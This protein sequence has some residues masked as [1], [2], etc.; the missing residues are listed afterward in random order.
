M[1]AL[2]DAIITYAILHKFTTPI[3]QSVAYKRG[4]VDEQGRPTEKAKHL[5]S[6]SDR[7]A[8]TLLDRL[9]F[10]LKRMFT[11]M[12]AFAKL[13]GGYAAALSFI[14]ESADHLDESASEEFAVFESLDNTSADYWG[15]VMLGEAI[16]PVELHHIVKIAENPSAL[17]QLVEAYQSGTQDIIYE[18]G[19]VAAAGM[20]SA[21]IGNGVSTGQVQGLATEPVIRPETQ[22]RWKDKNKGRKETEILS[23]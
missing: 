12:P 14:K 1:S 13:I 21:A 3:T 18:D 16:L 8:Y 19:G 11:G 9:V 7:D 23:N 10:R 4:L 5:V 15:R 6:D 20:S 22:K 17:R 2:S